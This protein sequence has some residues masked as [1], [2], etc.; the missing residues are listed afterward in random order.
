MAVVAR[1]ETQVSRRAREV[2][3]GLEADAAGAADDADETG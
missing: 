2:S 3:R 1:V